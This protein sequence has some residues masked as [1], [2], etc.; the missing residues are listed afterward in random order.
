MR[1]HNLDRVILITPNRHLLVVLPCSTSL[2]LKINSDDR[3]HN[4]PVPLNR[5]DAK[6]SKELKYL[7]FRFQKQIPLLVD[8]Y[9]PAIRA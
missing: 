4:N 5:L 7:K 9:F 8:R 3:H 6:T 1:S 2:S